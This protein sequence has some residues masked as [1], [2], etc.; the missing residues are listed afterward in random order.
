MDSV[1]SHLATLAFVS[2]ICCKMERLAGCWFIGVGPVSRIT[3]RQAMVSLQ[4]LTQLVW[5]TLSLV[6]EGWQSSQKFKGKDDLKLDEVCF[7]ALFMIRLKDSDFQVH[8]QKLLPHLSPAFSV[9]YTCDAADRCTAES[10]QWLV[11]L[12]MSPSGCY[13]AHG[14]TVHFLAALLDC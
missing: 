4:F 11:V 9:L 3:A 13:C 14:R 12:I 1:L 8:L 2:R 5:I 10:S 6:L 7:I